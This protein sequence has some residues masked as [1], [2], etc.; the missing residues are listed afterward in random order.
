[1]YSK[2]KIVNFLKD[3]IDSM[4]DSQ[5]FQKKVEKISIKLLLIP[6][7]DRVLHKFKPM[8]LKTV[9]ECMRSTSILIFLAETGEPPLSIRRIFSWPTHLFSGI[10]NESTT[11]LFQN[12]NF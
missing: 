8:I 9:L 5:W 2:T 10:S 11:P 12:C 6:H 7:K 1:M 3:Y 4:T